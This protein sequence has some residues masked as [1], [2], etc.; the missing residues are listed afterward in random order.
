MCRYTIPHGLFLQGLR[1][2]ATPIPVISTG[3]KTF[4]HSL[5]RYGATKFLERL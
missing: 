2:F 1:H 3:I 4:R 5:E